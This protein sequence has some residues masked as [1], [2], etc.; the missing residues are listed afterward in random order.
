ME[1]SEFCG[2]EKDFLRVLGQV[3]SQKSWC[4]LQFCETHIATYV[5]P[6]LT[7]MKAVA[8]EDLAIDSTYEPQ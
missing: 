8:D 2:G 3:N 6:F 4:L 5:D 1:E 7:L